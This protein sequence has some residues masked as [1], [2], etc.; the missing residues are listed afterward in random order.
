[1][2][3][4]EQNRSKTMYVVGTFAILSVIC[5]HM[6]LSLSTGSKGYYIDKIQNLFGT[7]GVAAFFIKSGYYYKRTK[8]DTLT[9]WKRKVLNLCIPWFFWSI[10]TYILNCILLRTSYS[11]VSQIKWTF[12]YGTW[13]YFAFALICLFAVFKPCYEK[14][15]GIIA[16]IV[17]SI[18]SNILTITGVLAGNSF[19]TGYTNFFNWAL[20]FAIGMLWRMNSKSTEE[21]T[22]SAVSKKIPVLI[23]SISAIVFVCI[24][25]FVMYRNLDVSYWQWWSVLFEF[26][27]VVVIYAIAY[28][29]RNSKVLC[30]IGR[31]TLFIYLT[32]MQICGAIKTR[33]PENAF[34]YGLKPL[35][36]LLVMTL[37]CY[38]AVKL[39]E[40]LKLEKYLFLFGIHTGKES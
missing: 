16:L 19:Y 26:A 4:K 40:V 25:V 35:V 14:T 9:F 29:F 18:I 11:V 17:I 33:I 12:G 21:R 34:A 39:F 27:G 30:F 15:F 10:L 6:K 7:I 2:T 24:T 5:A 20:F 8:G 38:A 3:I 22:N 28:V 37:I 23:L 31:N 13:Y 32:H 1:M 36:G